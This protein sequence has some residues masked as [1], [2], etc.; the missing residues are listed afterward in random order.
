[1]ERKGASKSMLLS[2]KNAI[3]TGCMRGIGRRMLI[4]FAENG[5][6]VWACCRS[7]T[8]EF[9]QFCEELGKSNNVRIT[10]LYFDITDTLK[11]K[12]AIMTILVA[13]VSV[14]ALVNNA[15]VTYSA[16]YQMTSLDKMREVFE[17]N[18]FAQ[19]AL[20]Q[21]VVKL[22]TRQK[23]GSIINISSTAALD[24][25]PGRSAY[26]A[27][28]AAVA[29][30]TR[31]MAHELAEQNIR[32]NAIAPGITDT[33][34]V[35][36]SMTSTAIE[37]AIQQTRLKRLGKPSEIADAAVFLASDL[38]SYVTGEVMRVDGGLQN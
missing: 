35:G 23:S 18:F 21:Y 13:K 6:N 4:A 31:V 38:A 34:M 7:K 29:C 33:D 36:E 19:I 26:G 20:T 3:I 32:V 15:G 22:M 11:M 28:K 1:M 8:T 24:A 12:E 16:L 9:D 14:D 37:E 25:N 2:G 5:A 10:P 27:S 17:V 30:I